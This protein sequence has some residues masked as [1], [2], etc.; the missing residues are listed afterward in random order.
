MTIKADGDGDDDD[1]VYDYE[2][3]EEYACAV[4]KAYDVGMN[5]R[6]LQPALQR[7]NFDQDQRKEPVDA[8]VQNGGVHHS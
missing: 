5:N 3:A 4:K 8:V 7:K 6:S 2:L 1:I